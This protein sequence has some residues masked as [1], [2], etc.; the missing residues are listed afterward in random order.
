MSPGYASRPGGSRVSKAS[1]R[2]VAAC[3]LRSSMTISACWP[4]SRKY[5]A[6]EKPAN[7]AIHCSPGADAADATTKTQRSGAPYLR[8][9]SMTRWTAPARWPAVTR[10]TD[11]IQ[12]PAEHAIADRH[13]DRFSARAHRGAASESRGRLQRERAHRS[14]AE[15]RLHLGDDGRQVCREDRDRVI[16][17]RQC[18]GLKLDVEH[19]TTHGLHAA[20]AG[21]RRCS[22]ARCFAIRRHLSISIRGYRDPFTIMG[23]AATRLIFVKELRQ[24]G[25]L[26]TPY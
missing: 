13:V 12:Q 15:M 18:A 10:F 22:S 3:L 23:F 7:G 11:D 1:S 8:T 14:A 5:S 19:R 25:A 20:R 21:S 17:R 9:A 6:I 26:Y 4:R 24:D 16:D 2:W